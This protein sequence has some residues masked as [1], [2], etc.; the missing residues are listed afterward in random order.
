M[1]QSVI[2]VEDAAP[3]TI[4]LEHTLT[5]LGLEVVAKTTSGIEAVKLAEELKPDFITL[6]TVLPDLLGIEVL[7]QI[8]SKNIKSKIIFISAAGSHQLIEEAI[9]EGADS[10]LVKPLKTDELK[11]LIKKLN[12]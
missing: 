10:Y 2:I 5:E 7:K 3:M 11:A 8:K 1:K 12:K 9:N 4:V 6:D